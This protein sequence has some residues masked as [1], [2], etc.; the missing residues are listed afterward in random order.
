MKG[1]LADNTAVLEKIADTPEEA[2]DRL[3]AIKAA[4]RRQHPRRRPCW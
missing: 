1:R 2:A 4:A 3:A